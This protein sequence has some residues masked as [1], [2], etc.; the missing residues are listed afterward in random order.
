M[1]GVIEGY[2][3]LLAQ[4]TEVIQ[5]TPNLLESARRFFRPDPVPY[6]VVCD[7][8]KRLYAVYRLGHRG[9]LAAT[10]AGVVSF[11]VSFTTGDIGSQ[12]R[13]AWH[14]VVNRNFL[15]RRPDLGGE[16]GGS[17]QHLRVHS[18]SRQLISRRRPGGVF[19]AEGAARPRR[20]FHDHHEGGAR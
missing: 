1:Q 9:V 18:P 6:P 5:V 11:A 16:H 4:A 10:R 13:G 17:G 8:D 15:P 12:L 19:F 14:D 7:P 20:R 2:Q 3:N